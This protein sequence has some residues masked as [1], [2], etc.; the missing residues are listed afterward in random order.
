MT[1]S[2]NTKYEFDNELKEVP[3]NPNEF[4]AAI[5]FLIAKAESSD[6]EEQGKILSKVGVMLRITGKLDES[7]ERLIEA[8][9]LISD[10]RILFINR[11][12]I[13][14]TL[15]FKRQFQNAESDYNSLI[16][17][18]KSESEFEDLI[19]FVYQHL[20]KCYF[21][22]NRFQKALLNFERALEIRNK[23]QNQELIDST[24]LA[25]RICKAK[26]EE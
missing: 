10:S 18:A 23:K 17:L 14:Q 1:L 8:E 2:F 16:V 22:Q 6:K 25:I 12:R 20:G 15:Q 26:L 7:M 4:I 9:K 3:K 21:D 13:A 5:E 19:D 24:E 11:L